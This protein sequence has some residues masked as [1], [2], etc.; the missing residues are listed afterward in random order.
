MDRDP[1]KSINLGGTHY[2]DSLCYIQ[3]DFLPVPPRVKTRSS[4]P[5]KGA[6]ER[7][8]HTQVNTMGDKLEKCADA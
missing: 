1:E 5:R 4:S 3:G 8:I 2:E 6:H 7:P